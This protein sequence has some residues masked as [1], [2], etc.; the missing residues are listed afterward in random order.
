MPVALLLVGFVLAYLLYVEVVPADLV[1][2]AGLYIQFFFWPTG[3][4]TF[5]IAGFLAPRAAYLIGF[6][7]GV[8][9]GLLWAVLIYFGTTLPVSVEPTEP[10]APTDPFTAA[11]NVFVV[12]I[13]TGTLA[14]AFAAWYRN[15]LRQMQERGKQ[16]RAERE[17]QERAKRR[18]ERRAARRGT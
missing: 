11:M 13:L 3:L 6:L 2:L 5:F 4:F 17:A 7:L 9:N 16:R 8:L 10:A 18:D 14:A 12:S 15:F 1:E